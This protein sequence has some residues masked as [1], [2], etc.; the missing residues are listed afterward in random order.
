MDTMIDFLSREH[1]AEL[2]WVLERV[3]DRAEQ[4][5]TEALAVIKL[6]YES[7]T[8]SMER[9]KFRLFLLDAARLVNYNTHV[10]CN[11]SSEELSKVCGV[12]DVLSTLQF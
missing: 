10:K 5:V 9:K 11:M 12:D 7:V 2:E 3:G 1:Q 8:M 4:A 6:D